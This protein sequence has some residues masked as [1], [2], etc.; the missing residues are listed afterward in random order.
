MR[1]RHRDGLLA[2]CTVRHGRI[3]QIE[4]HPVTRDEDN[5]VTDAHGAT[6]DATLGRVPTAVPAG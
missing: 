2:T 4:L 3:E 6:A 5:T 1:D